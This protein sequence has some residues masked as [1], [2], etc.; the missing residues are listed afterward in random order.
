[1]AKGKKVEK[2]VKV[3]Q[4][5]NAKRFLLFICGGIIIL[6]SITNLAL[7]AKNEIAKEKR[8][9]IENEIIYWENTVDKTPTY[10]D[11]YLKLA[12]LYWQLGNNEK[13]KDNFIK[14]QQID[15]NYEKTKELKKSL[16]L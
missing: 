6:L 14:A 3:V 9:P 16:G 7:W 2:V 11:G 8:A 15:P 5:K 10:R 1:M 13:A 4:V 12:T